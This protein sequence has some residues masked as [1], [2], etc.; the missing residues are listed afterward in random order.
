VSLFQHEVRE[1]ERQLERHETWTAEINGYYVILT[2]RDDGFCELSLAPVKWD[3][4]RLGILQCYP[5]RVA[6]IEAF[7]EVAGALFREVAANLRDAGLNDM[8]SKHD[9]LREKLD[10]VFESVGK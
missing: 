9:L 6:D 2:R 3:M 4:G 10:K 7:A 8:R 5:K 1:A